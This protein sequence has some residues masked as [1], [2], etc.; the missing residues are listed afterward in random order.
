MVFAAF[1]AARR[2]S[3]EDWDAYRRRGF[4][5]D[6]DFER[7]IGRGERQLRNV[8]LACLVVTVGLSG[9]AALYPDAIAR[10]RLASIRRL[11]G[12]DRPRTPSP[13]HRQLLMPPPRDRRIRV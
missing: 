1:D 2:V 10:P 11:M 7:G 9:L 6:E 5:V 12:R 4:V 13:I 8:L 3:M